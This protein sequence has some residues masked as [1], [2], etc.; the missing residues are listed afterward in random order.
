MLSSL[1]NL[2]KGQLVDNYVS[3]NYSRLYVLLMM[4]S[5]DFT[6]SHTQP[7]KAAE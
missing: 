5:I 1:Y 2:I 6:S 4:N 7:C 3:I